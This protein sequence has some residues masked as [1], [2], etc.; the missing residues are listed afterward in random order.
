MTETNNNNSIESKFVILREDLAKL[1]GIHVRTLDN[2]LRA[3]EETYPE[4][5]CLRR[6][7]GVK[8]FCFGDELT[9]VITLIA[10]ATAGN[11][12]LEELSDEENRLVDEA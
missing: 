12:N 4:K 5:E 10:L 3:A 11:E 1:F 9:E 6:K 7:F 2:H 8:W